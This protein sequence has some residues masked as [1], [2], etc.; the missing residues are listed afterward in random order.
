MN[1]LQRLFGVEKPLI[2][3]CHARAF[4]GR[5]LHDAGGWPDVTIDGLTRDLDALQAAGVDGLLFCNE[6]DLPYQLSV[7]PEVVAGMAS[8]IA[9]LRPAITL[10]FGVDLVWDARASLAVAR[11]TGAAF[12]RGVVTGVYDTDMGL[13]APNV[14]DLFAYRRHIDAQDVAVF[15]HI[16]PEFGRPVSGRSVYERAKGAAFMGADALLVSGLH[17]GL[18]VE[19]E[20][21]TQ[22]KSA[23]GA[24]PVLATSG[25]TVDSAKD[26]YSVADGAIVGTS[27]KVDGDTWKPVDPDRAIQMVRRVKELRGDAAAA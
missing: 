18:Q 24:V 12:V 5:P 22:A 6:E 7:G 19:L 20:D 1:V 13:L 21:L 11:A 23:A 14:G 9:R 27:L 16:T 15:A 3:M 17:T 25:V 4:P 26:I 10:P 8:L 2:G